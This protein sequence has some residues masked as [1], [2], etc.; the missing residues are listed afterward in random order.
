MNLKL[1]SLNIVPDLGLNLTNTPAGASKNEKHMCYLCV[2]YKLNVERSKIESEKE[3]ITGNFG[4]NV[5]IFPISKSSNKYIIESTS[6]KNNIIP[7]LTQID[8]AFHD[9]EHIPKLINQCNYEI[10]Q[11]GVETNHVFNAIQEKIKERES[12]RMQNEKLSREIISIK[13]NCNKVIKNAQLVKN[14]FEQ[15]EERINK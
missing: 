10:S 5:K 12:L 2:P 3:I 4:G 7:T 6:E 15:Y 13:E 1:P 8:T 9:V 11:L 14:K